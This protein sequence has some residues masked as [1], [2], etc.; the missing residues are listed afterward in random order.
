VL[1]SLPQHVKNKSE[2]TVFWDN[3]L[4]MKITTW[5]VNGIRAASEKGLF[6]WVDQ[7]RPDILCLQEIKARPEQVMLERVC[8]PGYYSYWYPA[9]QR[10]Y[11]GVATYMRKHP[12]AITAGLGQ[13][14]FDSEG[15]LQRIKLPDFIL[16]NIYFPN[17]GR[18]S[19]R[20]QY[21]LEFYEALLQEI[22][23]Y[24][25]QGV[26][27][28]VTGDFNTAHK[29]IDLANPKENSTISGFLPEERE[30]IDI[31]LDND[32][33]DAFRELYP[34][35]VK[36][37][38]WTYRF[39][40]RERNIGWRLDYFLVSRPLMDRVKDVVVHDEVLGSDHCPVSLLMDD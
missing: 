29:E 22:K 21:K 19:D 33:C 40:A 20:V 2:C 8:I 18:G 27:V 38:W 26:N 15:R 35:Q 24:H 34:A 23:L 3:H 37:T 5:N 13:E 32:L 6:E 1:L 10:G 14:R 31:F 25:S 7:T 4:M 28:I 17:G 12:L 9:E 30:W 11:S 16:Y 39:R 36:Y